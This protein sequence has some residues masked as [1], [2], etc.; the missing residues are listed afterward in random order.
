MDGGCRRVSPG[1][2]QE[3]QEKRIVAGPD[4]S[5]VLSRPVL[6]SFCRYLA[7]FLIP[8]LTI[9]GVM[10][11]LGIVPFG[12]TSL[13]VMDLR[14]QYKDYL[15]YLWDV[16]HGEGSLEYSA[17]KSL[18]GG[19]FGLYAYYLSSPLNLLLLLFE[20]SQIPLF[21]SVYTVLC[22]GL[23]GLTSQVYIRER[24][25]LPAFP[26]L[27]LSTSYALMEYNILY[28]SNVMWLNGV[29]MLPLVALGVYRAVHERKVGLL[30]AGVA[31][32]IISNWYTGYMVCLFSIFYCAFEYCLFTGLHPIASFRSQWRAIGCY[33]AAMVMGVLTSCAVLLPALLS[34]VG[35]R[36]SGL[37]G[38]TFA[39][40][41]DALHFFSGFEL[42][43]AVHSQSAPVVFCGG[44]M[45]LC[46]FYYF[47]D[48]KIGWRERA[49]SGAFAAFLIASF[50]LQDVE[51]LWTA[52]V[53]SS[54]YFFRFAFVVPFFM[55][56]LSSRAWQ[57]IG[58]LGVRR[59]SAVWSIGLVLAMF[60][61][62]Y[63]RGDLKSSGSDICTYMAFLVLVG[64]MAVLSRDCRRW[65]RTGAAACLSALLVVELACNAWV[66]FR[67]D[68]RSASELGGYIEQM[69]EVVAELDGLSDGAFYRF[70]RDVN[71]LT[72]SS[73]D[74]PDP[75]ATCESL[76]FGYGSIEHYSSTYDSAVDDFLALVG[77]SDCTGYGAFD[78]ETYWN[79]PMVLTDSLLSVRYA[80]L[81]D[82]TYGYEDAGVEAELPFEGG[83]VYENVWS[84][85]LGYNVSADMGDVEYGDDPYANQEALLSAMLGGEAGVYRDVEVVS[86]E[87]DG[88]DEVV[89]LRVED[90][91]P[92]YL[93]VDSDETHVGDE[94]FYENCEVYVDGELLQQCCTRFCFNSMLLGEFEEGDE[95]EVRI[96][97]I[98]GGDE[99]EAHVFHVAQLDADAFEEAMTGLSEGYESDLTVDGNVVSGTYSTEED[100]T[101]FLSIPYEDGWTLYVDGEEAEY[102]EL[103]GTFIGFDLEAGEH[104]VR[105]VYS[106]P[107]L[108][109]GAA[110]SC[111]G[112]ALFAAYEGAVHARRRRHGDGS[113]A[114]GAHMVGGAA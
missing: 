91:G 87:L 77:Y 10:A 49:L 52:Y 27:L 11:Y 35:G 59:S 48:S 13:M 111:T 78:A 63:F 68:D 8:A 2:G 15:G 14:F 79:S 58:E 65:V 19:T 105:L 82:A 57:S 23:C 97:C 51:L 42:M 54:S 70:E 73:S 6:R 28:C 69:E 109:A 101:V 112:I 30:Y 43:S 12:D 5:K 99:Q 88:G 44:L 16:L 107:G 106:T 29:I 39:V 55:I 31:L 74:E 18:G 103:A 1:E 50:C 46:S 84:L 67:E 4:V 80:V 75:E 34:L 86:D 62:L 85:P 83:D 102:R 96:A 20:K 98:D 100:A 47:C 113:T 38:I 36:A 72:L 95:V 3:M 7:A 53:Q 64:V 66:A 22:M 71:Y 21:L 32:A 56:F 104:E 92:V 76:L 17:G 81:D 61:V 60:A 41:F 93:Y 40:H 37:V 110:L 9:L 108:R 25:G 94:L 89:T 24:F 90:D 45:L 33:A 114:G 26:A